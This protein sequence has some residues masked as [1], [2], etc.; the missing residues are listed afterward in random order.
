[1]T[2]TAIS[3]FSQSAQQAQHWVNEVAGELDWDVPRAYRLLKAVL[4]ALRDWLPQEE[5]SDLAAQLP[6]LIRG[7]FFEGWYPLNGIGHDRRKSD[8]IV[9]VRR[10]FGFEEEIDFDRAIGAVFH[11]LDSHISAG[12]V[13][14]IR[15]SMRKA[16]RQLW[17]AD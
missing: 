5:M 11:L 8:F 17:P 1:M 2:T 12:E 6:T 9:A 10:E 4:H 7:V 3:N 14:Q 13:D 16:L 15:N